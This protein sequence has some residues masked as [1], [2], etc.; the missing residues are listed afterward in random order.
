MNALDIIL[1]AAVAGIVA[2]TV[3]KLVRD[4]KRGKGTCGCGCANCPTKCNR[5][6]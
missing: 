3:A 2:L 1:I 4:K 5:Q 6:R